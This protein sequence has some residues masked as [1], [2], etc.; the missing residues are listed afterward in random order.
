MVHHKPVSRRPVSSYGTKKLLTELIAVQTAFLLPE[1]E[2]AIE[3]VWDKKSN[4]MYP[5]LGCGI[6]KALSIGASIGGAPVPMPSASGVGR[7]ERKISEYS[8]SER[9]V[10]GED[11]S[12]L[13]L[14]ED[15]HK[16]IKHQPDHT[17][18]TTDTDKT[19]DQPNYT[20]SNDK[21]N[22]QPDYTMSIDTDKT[23]NQPDY[24]MSVDIDKT[25][26][27]PDYTM[28]IDTDK[29]NDQPNYTMS[30]DTDKTKDQHD[31]S[32]QIEVHNTLEPDEIEEKITL[33]RQ[34]TLASVDTNL[35]LKHKLENKGEN[36]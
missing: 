7:V 2:Q 11:S 8:L 25:N 29:I 15:S 23:N 6:A 12:E 33:E 27:Q 19:K 32:T 21:T 3:P 34:H 28:S 16:E 9:I 5:R 35:L 36:N 18:S 30:I 13:R 17:I 1:A 4:N 22:N 14:D 24:T 26:N 10:I 20:M 31:Y